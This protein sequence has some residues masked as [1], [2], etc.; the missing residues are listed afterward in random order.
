[1]LGNQSRRRKTLN[2]NPLNCL[3]I[4]LASHPVRTEGLVDIYTKATAI[5]I[6]LENMSQSSQLY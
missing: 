4:D 5:I 2:S 6:I 1:M 3:K